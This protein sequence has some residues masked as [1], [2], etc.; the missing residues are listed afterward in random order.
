MHG[1]HTWGTQQNTW[2]VS[3]IGLKKNKL[4]L[5]HSYSR[6]FAEVIKEILGRT[7]ASTCS[8]AG[9]DRL[10]LDLFPELLVNASTLDNAQRNIKTFHKKQIVF[11]DLDRK[12][13]C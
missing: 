2:P 5:I 3:R 8:Y 1:A 9:T 7:S 10:N 13:L 4:M 12:T 11:A 6:S